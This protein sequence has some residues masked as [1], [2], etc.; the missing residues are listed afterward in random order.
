MWKLN[1]PQSYSYVVVVSL[2]RC[3]GKGPRK[4]MSDVLLFEV[5]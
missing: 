4:S 2:A 3:K 1:S 5:Y